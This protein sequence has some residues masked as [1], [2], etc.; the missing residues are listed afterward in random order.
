MAT[1]EKSTYEKRSVVQRAMKNE[2]GQR[3]GRVPALEN[4]SAEVPLPGAYA[5]EV[6]KP[7]STLTSLAPVYMGWRATNRRRQQRLRAVP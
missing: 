6:P 2:R 3:G 4:E 5:V 1:D 7:P